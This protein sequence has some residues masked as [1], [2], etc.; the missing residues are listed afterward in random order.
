MMEA[1]TSMS[2]PSSTPRSGSVGSLRTP[3]RVRVTRAEVA[4]RA[5]VSKTT[6][7][8]VLSRTGGSHISPTTRKRVL[9]AARDLGYQPSFAARSLV[10]G[11][12][13]I[14]GLLLPSQEAQFGLYYSRMIAGVLDAAEDTPYHFLYL[15]Q[16]HPGKYR[17][18]LAQGYLDGVVVLQSLEDDRHV[19]AVSRSGLPAITMN[20]LS[21]TRLPAVSA[22]YEGA[23][24]LAC[25]ELLTQGSRRVAFLCLHVGSQPNLR[26]V[27]RH[28]VI[29]RELRE[30]LD[31][32]HVNLDGH[33]SVAAAYRSCIEGRGFDALIVDGMQN[34]TELVA[35]LGPDGRRMSAGPRLVVLHTDEGVREAP[36]GAM[37]LEAQPE[38]VGAEA[39][40]V[41]S[42]LLHRES[43]EARTLI[44]YRWRQI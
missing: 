31:T 1:A 24:D 23:V 29:A 16:N 18:C 6:V 9:Q 13:L 38:L 3:P 8:Y 14:V 22:D 32:V 35:A 30:R 11:R 5:G 36:S 21:R 37:V 28:A 25:Q 4:R 12:T 33:P 39:W 7:T 2:A 41:M 43:V 34:A 20:Y 15:G 42:L 27:A 44:P 17:R 40:R 26:H 19:R 10:E